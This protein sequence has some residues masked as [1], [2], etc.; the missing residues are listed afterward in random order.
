MHKIVEILDA[1]V[2]K[3]HT[4]V[5]IEHNLDFIAAS[6]HII[7]LGPSAGDKGGTPVA[8]GIL[9]EITKARKSLTVAFLKRFA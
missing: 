2:A 3:G 5:A 1:L 6:D 7:D 9:Q 8:Q 4:V